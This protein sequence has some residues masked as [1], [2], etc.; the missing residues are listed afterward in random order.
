MSICGL[1]GGAAAIATE[2]GQRDREHD[3]RNEL[4][5]ASTTPRRAGR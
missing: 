1:G 2:A 3:D 4:A 5:H